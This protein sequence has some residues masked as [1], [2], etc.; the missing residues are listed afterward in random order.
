MI[1]LYSAS[2][3]V[4]SGIREI[5]LTYIGFMTLCIISKLDKLRILKLTDQ[6]AM[7]GSGNDN[8]DSHHSFIERPRSSCEMPRVPG[9]KYVLLND[10]KSI[11]RFKKLAFSCVNRENVS[12]SL[13]HDSVL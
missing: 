12:S 6:H 7:T 5:T 3:K 4:L 11:A 10:K 1:V 2:C 8:R 13:F 9:I